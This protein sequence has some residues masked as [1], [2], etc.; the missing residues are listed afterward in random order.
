VYLVDHR[1][2]DYESR[3]PTN[4]SNIRNDLVFLI[5]LFASCEGFNYFITFDIRH[6]DCQLK[7]SHESKFPLQLL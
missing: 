3:V 4:S 6:R 2:T 7:K 1:S 5:G